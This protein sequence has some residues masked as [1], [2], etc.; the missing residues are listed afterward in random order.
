MEKDGLDDR[1]VLDC[2]VPH[3]TAA[4]LALY[5]NPEMSEEHSKNYE[6]LVNEMHV[7]ATAIKVAESVSYELTEEVLLLMQEKMNC[8]RLLWI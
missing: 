5:N 1:T 2:L 4:Y 6:L 7:L 8:K 3:D